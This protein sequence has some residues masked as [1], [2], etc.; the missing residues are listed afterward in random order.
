MERNIEDYQGF[1]TPAQLHK[2]INTLRGIVA[3]ITADAKLETNEMHELIHWCQLHSHLR[4]R[5]PFSEL[6]PAMEKACADGTISDDKAQDIL[7]L[8]NNFTDNSS[9]Y[10][11]VTS[12][13][14]FLSGM[15]HGIMADGQLEDCEIEALQ[16]WIHAN[17]YLAGTYPYDEINS[18]LY[19][20]ME[21]NVIT[22]QEKELL[23]AF[24][25]TIIEFK[26]SLNLVERDY[27]DIRTHC[28]VDGVCTLNPE[29]IPTGHIFCLTGEFSHGTRGEM[30]D[31]LVMAGGI[32]RTSVNRKTDYL[33]VGS[34]GNPC[35][36][37]SC[38]GRKVEEAIRLRREGAKVMVVREDD[39]W[40]AL[41]REE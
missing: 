28:G 38:Y 12:S 6:L 1:T 34:I 26:D 21:D 25:S 37:Y 36:A 30:I 4:T 9:Y 23:Q 15:I 17:K 40:T 31:A 41:G 10:D 13:I 35:W 29:I 39:F 11:T 7:W 22:S 2:S 5:H 33:V 27:I 20:I 8:C 19:S 32:P 14:Q 3:G 16:K 18:L 24:F